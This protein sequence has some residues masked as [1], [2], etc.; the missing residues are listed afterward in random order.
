VTIIRNTGLL[1]LGWNSHPNIWIDI[2]D[3]GKDSIREIIAVLS[4]VTTRKTTADLDALL[5]EQLPHFFDQRFNLPTARFGATSFWEHLYGFK[6]VCY[7]LIAQG[8]VT[9]PNKMQDIMACVS[10][11]LDRYNRWMVNHAQ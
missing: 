1:A 3:E 5:M 8:F 4:T 9:N 2:H 6:T 11:A 7:S 10:S